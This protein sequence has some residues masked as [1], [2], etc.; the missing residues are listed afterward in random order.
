MN[1]NQ[2]IALGVGAAVVALMLLFPPFQLQYRGTVIN[3]GYGLIFKPPAYERSDS[4]LGSVNTG[5]LLVQWIGVIV[6][7]GVI[8]FFLKSPLNMVST[9][10]PER[11]ELSQNGHKQIPEIQI[12]QRKAFLGGHYYPWRRFFARVVDVYTTGLTVFFVLA[13]ALRFFSPEKFAELSELVNNKF[14]SSFIILALWFPAEAI[15]LKT[16]GT[17]PAKWLF[18][19]RVHCSDGSRLSFRQALDRSFLV[20]MQGIGFGIP[21]VVLF[22]QLYAY[23][24]LTNTGTTLWDSSSNAV[25]THKDWGIVRS[26]SCGIAVFGVIAI[27]G[28]LSP[29]V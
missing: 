29:R 12:D 27:A 14:I 8:A 24:R 16:L 21:I 10:V 25:V 5:T 19:I 3:L 9:I 23:Q 7:T 13:F 18:G 6:L 22:T 15:F 11:N 1:R 2:K 4:I 26:I 20:W 17:T 28:I